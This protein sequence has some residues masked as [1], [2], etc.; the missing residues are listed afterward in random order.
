MLSI[1]R[2]C[3]LIIIFLFSLTNL[4]SCQNKGVQYEKLKEIKDTHKI[5]SDKVIKSILQLIE[6]DSIYGS[7]ESEVLLLYVQKKEKIYNFCLS[8]TNYIIFKKNRPKLFRDLKGKT[9]IENRSVLLFGNIDGNYFEE[10]EEHIID[11]LGDMPVYTKDNPPII[12]E[13]KM[14]CFEIE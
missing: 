4:V 3:S 14:I 5:N 12:Y 7:S 1:N 2:Y 8:K 9:S 11:V 6:N 13:P 10:D